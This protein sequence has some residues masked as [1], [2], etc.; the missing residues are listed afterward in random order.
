MQNVPQS[1]NAAEA[2]AV[3]EPSPPSTPAPPSRFQWFSGGRFT[4]GTFKKSKKD[5][6]SKKAEKPKK[7]KNAATYTGSGSMNKSRIGQRY[8]RQGIGCMNVIVVPDAAMDGGQRIELAVDSTDTISDV[9]QQIFR[10]LR[11][12]TNLRLTFA[13]KYLA[14]DKTLA[15]CNI[16]DGS[17]L[18]YRSRAAVVAK[19]ARLRVTKNRS[20]KRIDWRA[21]GC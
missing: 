19:L 8:K 1:R 18:T 14:D 3:A 12:E 2:D 9:K 15:F 20:T 5:K 11:W 13:G 7:I 10:H 17:T 21:N 4:A 16:T 6:K